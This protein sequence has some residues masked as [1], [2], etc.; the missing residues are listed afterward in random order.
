M[1]LYISN[2]FIWSHLYY[3]GLVSLQTHA[4]SHILLRSEMVKEAFVKI[5]AQRGLWGMAYVQMGAGGRKK[6]LFWHFLWNFYWCLILSFSFA[7]SSV[8]LL[9]NILDTYLLHPIFVIKNSSPLTSHK[10]YQYKYFTSLKIKLIKRT[11]LK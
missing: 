7:S 8:L 11:F 4:R 3:T 6:G 1:S 2:V 9:L 10:Y 5:C